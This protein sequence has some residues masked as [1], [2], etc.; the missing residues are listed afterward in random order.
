MPCKDPLTN[1]VAARGFTG[2]RF[3]RADIKAGTLIAKQ[4][5]QVAELG[6]V[7]EA[8][9]STES[10][11]VPA[12]P[13]PASDFEGRS[14]DAVSASVGL[15]VLDDLL[16][17]IGGGASVKAAYQGAGSIIFRVGG[18]TTQAVSPLALDKWLDGAHL[19]TRSPLLAPFVEGHG[20]LF[21]ITR[22]LSAT[23][24][25]VAA[26]DQRGAALAVDVPALSKL[27]D[28]HLTVDASGRDEGY[29][30]Y[31]GSTPVVFAFQALRMFVDGGCVRLT[32]APPGSAPLA[33]APAEATPTPLF[34]EWIEYTTPYG[35]CFSPTPPEHAKDVSRVK[36]A[37]LAKK[38]MWRHD[39]QIDI[40]FLEG[41]ERLKQ[42][43]REAAEEWRRRAGLPLTF[44]W[45][46][47]TD[48]RVRIAFQP[49][50]GSWS[51]LGTDCENHAGP[52]MNFGW[53]NENS[54]DAD[55]RSVVLHEFGHMLGLIH[56]HQH[57]NVHIP[58]NK[59][60]VYAELG[61]PPN[62][63]SR[64]VV[65]ANLFKPY[66]AR[67]VFAGDYDET[68]IMHYPVP[69]SWTDGRFVVGVNQ[70]LSEK[71]IATVREAY[72]VTNG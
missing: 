15:G 33:L 9:D 31:R 66:D 14:S 63:W 68:S 18:V 45:K 69:A 26:V 10:P 2:V 55:L 35:W 67:E 13:A 5:R 72:G 29:L 1:L 23:E 22:I 46:M 39:E 4:S 24:L 56:E 17:V 52:T 62:R 70:S 3:P 61:G 53:I 64:D 34:D 6:N 49:G 59:E 40:V 51:W 42:R 37:A 54:D 58:W 47:G 32:Q 71:D 27:L 8:F 44:V 21:V 50:R 38:F 30:T 41:S 36:R 20:Q 65:D 57:P 7:A 19:R 28:A 11:P 60:A 25:S 48:A 43:V 12:T 16:R